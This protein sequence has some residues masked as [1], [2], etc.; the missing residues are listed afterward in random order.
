VD[1]LGSSHPPSGELLQTDF[2]VSI[3][4]DYLNALLCVLLHH[5]I[6]VV[7]VCIQVLQLCE[8]PSKI[9]DRQSLILELGKFVEAGF[10]LINLLVILLLQVGNA[11]FVL[12]LA[13]AHGVRA[14][15]AI[16]I[17]LDVGFNR[18]VA[19][20]LESTPVLV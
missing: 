15:I 10:D 1:A 16:S 7:V 19:V 2:V 17:L 9:L 20:L 18:D 4:V 3:L 6:W 13:E 11:L 12:V 5:F 14:S 8:E